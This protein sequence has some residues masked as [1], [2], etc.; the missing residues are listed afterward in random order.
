[1]KLLV[2]CFLIFALMSPRLSANEG[3]SNVG[4]ELLI[5]ANPISLLLKFTL[6]L[7]F[8]ASCDY[9]APLKFKPFCFPLGIKTSDAYDLQYSGVF[10]KDFFL[11][12]RNRE[13]LRDFLREFLLALQKAGESDQTIN[14]WDWAVSYFGGDQDLA[15][16][17]ISTLFGDTYRY[18]YPFAT[19][20]NFDSDPQIKG[21]FAG[22]ILE[23]KAARVRVLKNGRHLL[24]CY[25]RPFENPKSKSLYHFYTMALISRKFLAHHFPKETV[26]LAT[27]VLQYL[28]EDYIS[29]VDFIRSDYIKGIDPHQTN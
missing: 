19:Q 21:Y 12:G 26:I 27:H 24:E 14:L 13:K 10:Q 11:M 2:G 9:Y 28:Y 23:L 4:K 25:P 17:Y 1:M 8:F 5:S 15:L 22:A 3:V 7:G 16:I 6:P 20:F 29:S 18:D